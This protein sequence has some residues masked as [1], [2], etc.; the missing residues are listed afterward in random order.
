L[1]LARERLDRTELEYE[2]WE[3]LRKTMREAEQEEG[4]NLGRALT[5]P[6]TQRFEALTGGRYGKFVLGAELETEGISAGGETRDVGLLSVGTRDQLST[7]FRL[8]LAEQLKTAVIL[9]DQLAQSDS[10]RMSWL[11]DLLQ[12]V[13]GNVQVIVLTCRPADYVYALPLRKRNKRSEEQTPVHAIDL[14][15]FIKRSQPAAL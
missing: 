5:A 13:A 4:T 8:T 6:I 12:E 9:D 1:E 2:A 11:R 14:L 3:L 7:I 10:T 15:N